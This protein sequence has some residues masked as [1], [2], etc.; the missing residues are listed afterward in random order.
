M[1]ADTSG[2]ATRN[3]QSFIYTHLRTLRIIQDH[4]KKE[5]IDLSMV[6][7]T[8]VSWAY[9]LGAVPL[10]CL[11]FWHAADAWYRAAFFLKHGSKKDSNG[12]RR[13]LPP[14]HMGL[15]FLGETISLL[16]Y[17]KRLR[18]PDEFIR[19][20]RRAYGGEE[21]GMYRTHLFG[22]P[23]VVVCAPAANKFVF[24][25]GGDTFGVRWPVPELVGLKAIGVV[26]GGHHTRLRGVI[27]G[28]INRPS[29][30]RTIA[31]VVQPSIVAAFNSWAGMGT[32]VAS[33]EAKK[34]SELMKYYYVQY[35]IQLNYS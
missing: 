5:I 15:P 24:Q 3:P 23:T 30:L 26:E 20:K 7:M 11:A 1:A 22:S 8:I 18:R 35:I 13:R 10:L 17:F 12:V 9:L 2:S 32:I 29:S 6:A 28:A 27:V 33:D 21:V 19:A 16:W 34:V 4:I 14:G 25:A 31:A